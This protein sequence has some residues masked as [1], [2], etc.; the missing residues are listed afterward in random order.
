MTE[1]LLKNYILKKIKKMFSDYYVK[2]DEFIINYDKS[3]S[4]RVDLL[5]KHKNKNQFIIVEIKP[6]INEKAIT[7]INKY[8]TYFILKHN[9]KPY[10]VRRVLIGFN[11]S[12][13]LKLLCKYSNIECKI[14]PKNIFDDWHKKLTKESES[15]EEQILNLLKNSENPISTREICLRLNHAW[16]SVN[17]RCLRLQIEGKIDGFKVG[18]VNLWT[19]KRESK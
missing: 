12:K 1:E 2:D 14:V 13:K 7:Q 8:F 3:G 11:T 18:H 4:G 17:N 19:L 16:H 10:D 6:S 9:L 5:L 15:I